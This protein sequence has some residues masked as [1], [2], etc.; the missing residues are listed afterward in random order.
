VGLIV[1]GNRTVYLRSGSVVPTSIPTRYKRRDGYVYLTWI[2]SP[3]RYATV[4]EHRVVNGVVVDSESV[5]HINGDRSD[6]RPENLRQMSASETMRSVI[7]S[8]KLR[9][10][11]KPK[12]VCINGHS[13][14]N[15][16]IRRSNL[17]QVCL[18][19]ANDRKA[20]VCPMCG[21]FQTCLRR[22]MTKRQRPCNRKG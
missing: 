16:G 17:T 11:P 15:A 2:V 5:H 18:I 9:P 22:H 1:A 20:G 13:M 19:C 10:R 8:L 21:K 6:N 12:A 4:A 7:E 14:A 3:G